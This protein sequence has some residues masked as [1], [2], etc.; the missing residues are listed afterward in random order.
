M[1]IFASLN[2]EP[3]V[4]K[5][6]G[7]DVF[8]GKI[9]H[10][11]DFKEHVFRDI[12]RQKKKVAVIGGGKTSIDLLLPFLKAGYSKSISWIYRRPYL[13]AKMENA[14]GESKDGPPS[15]AK[16]FLGLS[17][18][19][20]ILLSPISTQLSRW[21]MWCAGFVWTYDNNGGNAPYVYKNAQVDKEQRTV[22]EGFDP[23]KRFRSGI[24]RFESNGIRLQDGRFVEADVVLLATSMTNGFNKLQ[25]TK[26][27][28]RYVVDPEE[29]L[30]NGFALQSFPVLGCHSAGFY[31][32]PQRAR[33]VGDLALY[34]LCVLENPVSIDEGHKIARLQFGALFYAKVLLSGN[35]F[36]A[37][38][39]GLLDIQTQG[40]V[41]H[42]LSG[43]INFYVGLAALFKV[44]VLGRQDPLD[45]T[46]LP[47]SSSLI[48]DTA[49]LHNDA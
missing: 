8:E 30:L 11:Q 39:G 17:N 36:F 22:M 12:V 18:I 5:F 43:T 24:E 35:F 7:Q 32:G 3:N 10:S 2:C 47:P 14:F 13:F 21:I 9:L 1:V 28:E 48:A 4:P 29:P 44:Y 45:L 37:K 49:K 41:S 40:L 34:H 33:I 23:N 38:S 27:G 15:L 26:D 25:L 16:I 20:A 6:D 31:V 46:I 19:L 42:V